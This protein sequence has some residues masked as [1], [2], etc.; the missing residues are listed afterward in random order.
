LNG[1]IDRVVRIAGML[2]LTASLTFIAALLGSL[3]GLLAAPVV[4]AG[5]T[6]L[7]LRFQLRSRPVWFPPL[8]L[9]LAVLVAEIVV[10]TTL[11]HDLTGWFA[12]L[13]AAL[14]AALT[15]W[16]LERSRAQ[17]NLCGRRLT[18]QAVV[19]HCPRCLLK[20]CDETCWNF[21]HRRCRLCL[22]QRVPALPV[23]D[24]WWTRTTGPRMTVGRC[25]VCLGSAEQVDLRACPHCR[26]QQC[27]DCWDFGNGECARCAKALPDLPASFVLAAAE[28]PEV[29]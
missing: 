20:V 24:S 17:C 13:L 19:F 15:F 26:R 9:A 18:S 27:R 14:A 5:A 22:E 16:L 1:A 28:V 7:W 10:E 8:A 6:W 2:V 21:D 12:P 4:S 11:R 3:V 25:Q 23:Q 29:Q